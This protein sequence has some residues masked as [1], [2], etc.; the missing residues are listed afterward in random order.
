MAPVFMVRPAVGVSQ[1]A[2]Q[3]IDLVKPVGETSHA[4]QI[5]PQGTMGE[6]SGLLKPG[7]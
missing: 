6:N 3:L 5:G 7:A 1:I 4:K 2:V